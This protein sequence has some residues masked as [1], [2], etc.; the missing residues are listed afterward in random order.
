MDTLALHAFFVHA[1]SA[2]NYMYCNYIMYI[3][4][5]DFYNNCGNPVGQWWNEQ[6][7]QQH[8]NEN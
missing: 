6:G 2:L 7:M 5:V 4:Y 3:I 8:K 1:A